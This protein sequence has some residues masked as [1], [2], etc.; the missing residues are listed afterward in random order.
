MIDCIPDAY[1][2]AQKRAGVQTTADFV[3]ITMVYAVKRH[4]VRMFPKDMQDRDRMG[5]CYAGS[6]FDEGIAHP[7]LFDFYLQSHTALQGSM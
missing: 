7:T 2:L 4:H 3:E 5:N 1:R 6:V